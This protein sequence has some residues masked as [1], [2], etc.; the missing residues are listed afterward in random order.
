MIMALID[1]VLRPEIVTTQRLKHWD[2]IPSRVSPGGDLIHR[3][4]Q[5]NYLV[6]QIV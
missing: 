6:H 4:V 2:D 5:L 1:P 3:T